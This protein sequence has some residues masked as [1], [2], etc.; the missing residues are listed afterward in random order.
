MKRDVSGPAVTE[1]VIVACVVIVLF[2]LTAA[3][4]YTDAATVT[5]VNSLA[6]LK[7]VK[8]L[9]PLE[10]EY[11]EQV[12]RVHPLTQDTVVQGIS[13]VDKQTDQFDA[14]RLY[15]WSAGDT[16]AS[17]AKRLAASQIDWI[18]IAERNNYDAGKMPA[19]GSV[20]RIPRASITKNYNSQQIHPSSDYG[21]SQSTS[22]KKP[23]SYSASKTNVTAP[24]AQTAKNLSSAHTN[25][26]H[27]DSGLPSDAQRLAEQY[28]ASMLTPSDITLAS[29][30]S[31]NGSALDAILDTPYTQG[32]N[33]SFVSRKV[34]MF[35]GEA[36][37]F[38]KVDVKRVAVGNGDVLRA[39]VLGNGDLLAIA[40]TAGS[41]SL[42]LWHKDGSRSDFNIRILAED[43]EVRV[44][45][46]K[47]IRMRVKMIE[48]RRSE[49][50]RLGIDWG[51]SIE[52]PVFATAGDLITN[53]LFRPDSGVLGGNLPLAVQPFNAYLGLT[54]QLSSRINFLVANGDAEMLAEPVLTSINGG[55]AKFLAGGEVPYPTVGANGQTNIE[56]REYGIRLEISPIADQNGTIQ[57]SILT[58]VSSIDPAV[59]VMEAPGLL[60]RRTQTQISVIAG[61]TIVIGGLLQSESGKDI[62]S[63]PGLGKLPILGKLF[64]SDNLRNNVSELVIFITPEIVDPSRPSLNQAQV[65]TNAY[66]RER[67]KQ[68]AQLLQKLRKQ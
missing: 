6:Q 5:P 30:S 22:K 26:L 34:D 10:T 50:K 12:V 9:E 32:L 35:T 60:T 33:D 25:L 45:L 21:R 2:C 64:R 63:L 46:E 1:I 24:K 13:Q 27:A 66:A 28:D 62:D 67:L 38:G 49:L 52:G 29:L 3:R 11:H 37:V 14:D 57:A 15:Y 59:T 23:H 42:H 7:P 4:N 65:D 19:V 31:V 51:D 58:E 55:S 17:L 40:L 41:S 53:S 36:R 39:E 56:F 68:Q 8:S 20:I 61:D 54:A 43:P 16:P 48:F 44:K 47:S 18:M